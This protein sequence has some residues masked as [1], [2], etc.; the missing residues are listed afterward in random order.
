MK[1]CILDLS[2]ACKEFKIEFSDKFT[3][4]I[5]NEKEIFKQSGTSITDFPLEIQFE[6]HQ[7]LYEMNLNEADYTNLSVQIYPPVDKY[8]CFN[9]KIEITDSGT[10]DRCLAVT[11]FKEIFTLKPNVDIGHATAPGKTLL[12]NSCLHFYNASSCGLEVTFTDE[13]TSI[14][15]PKP[16]FRSG[17]TE[18]KDPKKRIVFVLDVYPNDARLKR[19]MEK[20][21]TVMSSLGDKKEEVLEEQDI[22]D[23]I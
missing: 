3:T 11:G 2:K 16:G 9:N 14:R 20:L 1:T 6:L 12:P 23:L 19:M 8:S 17:M 5:K 13:K 4:W 22:S 18:K 10:L 15:P 7:M 21:Q